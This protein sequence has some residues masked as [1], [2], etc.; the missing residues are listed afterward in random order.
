MQ[1][2]NAITEKMVL[3][4]ILQARDSWPLSARLTD[5]GAGGFSS[6]VGEMG[7]DLGADVELDKRPAQI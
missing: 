5:C 3:D 4:V 2:G 6:A 1:I 7:A